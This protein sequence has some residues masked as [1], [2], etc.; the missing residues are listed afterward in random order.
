MALSSKYVLAV[1][2]VL[3]LS[4]GQADAKN[5]V[6][7]DGLTNVSVVYPDVWDMANNQKPGDILTIAGPTHDG[8]NDHAFCRMNVSDDRRF[9]IYPVQYSDEIQRVN[10]SF[11]FW[12]DYAARYNNVNMV[13]V[14]DNAGM[15]RGAASMADFTFEPVQGGMVKRAM[16][17]ASLYNNRLHVL[18]CSSEASAFEAWL[19]TFRSILSSVDFRKV[20]HETPHGY[21][22]NFL[23]DKPLKVHGSVPEDNYT[24]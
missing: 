3:C 13:E 11:D 5:F 12:E 8:I 23:A 16:A 2:A 14:R 10:F 17:L 18:E 21:Y 19:P 4:A 24:F 1:C 15:G 20:I 9:A 6:W 22:R 7:K